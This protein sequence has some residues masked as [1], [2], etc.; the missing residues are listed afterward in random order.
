MNRDRRRILV[1]ILAM[2]AGAAFGAC[3]AG[4]RT[5]NGGEPASADAAAVAPE[6]SAA[7]ESDNPCVSS[8]C[9]ASILSG[10][11]VHDAAEGC[12]DCHSATSE[13][14]PVKGEKTFELLNDVPDLCYACHDE[15]G[16]GKTVHSPAGDGECMEC[17]NPHSTDEAALL[18][19]PMGEVCGECHETAEGKFVHGPVADGDCTACHN[20]HET[21]TDSLL[22][23]TGSE[24]CTE[25]HTSVAEEIEAA[26]VAHG[27][28]DA[29]EGCIECHSPHASDWSALTKDS[30]RAVCLECHDTDVP[31]DAKVLHGKENSGDCSDCH[32][33]HGGDLEV[34]LVGT[35]PAAQYVPWTNDA[36]PLCFSC[37]D[38]TLV[39]DVETTSAT[40]FRDERRNLHAAHVFDEEKGRSCRFCHAWHG[41]DQPRLLQ[42]K[43]PFG[44]WSFSLK[45]VKTETGGG[46]AP[47]CHKPQYYDREQAGRKPPGV[48]T[49]VDKGA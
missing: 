32:A 3:Q 16:K 42:E 29:G 4:M 1:A 18:K 49:R 25:C 8:K 13:A 6:G 24:L 20:P 43:V 5:G 14:H 2:A 11:L 27:A 7:A 30:V 36:Y 39:T 10:K 21:D 47:A 26:A 35:F 34:L 33:P 31:T 22:L 17:H 23:K 44:K 45:F 48:R 40:G 28:L 19:A 12:T 46:C 41:S 38:R 9:H 15:Y 37:H